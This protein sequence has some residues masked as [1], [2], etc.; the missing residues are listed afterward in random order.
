VVGGIVAYLDAAT[1]A[2]LMQPCASDAEV[3]SKEL[4]AWNADAAR[5]TATV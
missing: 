2:A 1:C 4:Q 5:W 3:G